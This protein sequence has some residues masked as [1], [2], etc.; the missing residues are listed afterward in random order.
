MDTWQ[1]PPLD[2]ANYHKRS[3]LD[4]QMPTPKQSPTMSSLLSSHKR[5]RR[6]RLPSHGAERRLGRATTLRSKSPRRARAEGVSGQRK[7]IVLRLADDYKG[8]VT[9]R[10]KRLKCDETRPHCQRCERRKV[11]CGGYK[12]TFKWKPFDLNSGTTDARQ[13]RKSEAPWSQ[14]CFHT[15]HPRQSPCLRPVHVWLALGCQ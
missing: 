9:C 4:H 11:E 1:P 14:G 15:D 10:E 3:P 8:C 2:R 12:T 7:I 5:R 13:S 6:R